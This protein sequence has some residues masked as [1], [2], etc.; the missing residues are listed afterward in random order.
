MASKDCGRVLTDAQ[1]AVLEPLVLAVRPA[2]KTPHEDLRRTLEAIIWRHRNGAPWRAIPAVLGAWHNAAQ[3]FIRWGKQGV[4][5]R[6]LA[7]A[8]KHAGGIE[9]GMAFLDGTNVRAHAKAA[10][11]PKKGGLDPNETRVR[12]LDALVAALAPR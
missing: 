12:R 2:A 6:L 11:A 3:T 10:G 9:L 4:W 1:W 5:E 8:Q 7:L